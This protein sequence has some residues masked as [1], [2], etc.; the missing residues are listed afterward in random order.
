MGARYGFYAKKPFL[1]SRFVNYFTQ[2]ALILIL[3]AWFII[4]LYCFIGYEIKKSFIFVPMRWKKA[5]VVGFKV[6]A[7]LGSTGF[8]AHRLW[9]E[10]NTGLLNQG[11][12]NLNGSWAILLLVS[13]I[14]MFVNW[15]LETLKWRLLLQPIQPISRKQ[16]VKSV[17]SGITVSI[18]TP[19]RVGEFAGRV[20]VLS[21]N[22]RI[23]GVV[24]TMIGNLT[25]LLVTLSVGLVFSP[26]FLQRFPNSININTHWVYLFS[27]LQ[28]VL[29]FLVIIKWKAIIQMV[30]HWPILK[31]YP[32]FFKGFENYAKKDFFWILGL[33]LF[34]YLVFGM[35][36]YL[37][38]TLFNVSVT[39]SEAV[40]GIT[41]FY[42]LMTL[43]PTFAMS[44]LGIRGSVAMV[45]F[46][47]FTPITVGVLAA[48]VVLWFMNLAIP[49]LFGAI[50]LYQYKI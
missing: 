10:W 46:G 37:L 34:R 20:F 8:I 32:A 26:F 16:S 12:H 40:L 28:L 29:G 49:A 4:S 39:K 22:N 14:L 15:G 48:S 24:A 5:L 2:C 42:F 33:S 6:A 30:R 17:L 27:L 31:K 9:Y 21:E 47:L 13:F 19:N 1:K 44:E 25:Q 11:I 36:F 7:I 18:F 38:L 23:Q 45:I 43:I 3:K 41:Q 50:F 35:Q